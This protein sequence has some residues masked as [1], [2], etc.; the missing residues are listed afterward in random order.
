LTAVNVVIVYAIIECQ[1]TD[2]KTRHSSPFVIVVVAIV[3]YL[4]IKAHENIRRCKM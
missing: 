1:Q 3:I 4:F 2:K